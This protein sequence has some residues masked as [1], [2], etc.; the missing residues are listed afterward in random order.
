MPYPLK[1][2][3]FL[4]HCDKSE[5]DFVLTIGNIVYLFFT[6]VDDDGKQY[7]KSLEDFESMMEDREK[8]LLKEKG[9][10]SYIKEIYPHL[11][12][13]FSFYQLIKQVATKE[14]IGVL[15][16]IRSIVNNR[17]PIYAENSKQQS[18]L[19]DEIAMI[20]YKPPNILG[21]SMCVYI[22]I[23]EFVMDFVFEEYKKFIKTI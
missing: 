17:Y 14:D 12:D 1:I 9:N 13:T 21:S 6:D 22:A 8:F 15:E 3:K 5:D 18:Q 4:N 7:F 19:L 11:F 23:M 20:I 16:K 2:E 10:S